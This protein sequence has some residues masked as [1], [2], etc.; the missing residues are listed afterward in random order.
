MGKFRLRSETAKGK[1]KV[2]LEQ[3]P[4]KRGRKTN[5]EHLENLVANYIMG[6]SSPVRQQIRGWERDL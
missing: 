5:Q 3:V 1:K 2:Q 4:K 6:N